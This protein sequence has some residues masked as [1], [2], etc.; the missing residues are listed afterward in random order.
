VKKLQGIA[1]VGVLS[2]SINGYLTASL[3]SRLLSHGILIGLVMEVF[4]E[5]GRVHS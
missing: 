5:D 3:G 4:S 2:V 1:D